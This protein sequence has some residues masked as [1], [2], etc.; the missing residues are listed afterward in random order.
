MALP[1]FRRMKWISGASS[2]AKAIPSNGGFVA[3][4]QGACDLPATFWRLRFRHRFSA[5]TWRHRRSRPS[6][7]LWQF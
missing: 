1:E 3:V 2:L 6:V 4:S 5:A 7:L